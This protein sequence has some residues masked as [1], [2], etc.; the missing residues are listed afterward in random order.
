MGQYVASG[1]QKYLEQ[2]FDNANTP[3]YHFLLTLSDDE[4]AKDICQKTWLK[5]MESKH[6]YRSDGRFQAWLFTIGRRLLLD[7]YRK[8]NRLQQLEDETAIMSMT[9]PTDTTELTQAF[10]WALMQ[11]PWLQ[12]EAFALQQE[13]FG[14]A[15]IGDITHASYETVKS[16]IRYA[17]KTLSSLLEKYRE[18]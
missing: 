11:L 2:L 3:L 13:G 1:E 16:R 10:E 6:L 18:Q 9:I 12:R 7:E 14:I 15:E 5:V 8:T 4:L 17:K